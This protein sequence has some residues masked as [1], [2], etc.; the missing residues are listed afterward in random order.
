MTEIERNLRL[1]AS[2]EELRSIGPWLTECLQ[3]TD[4][5]ARVGE[6]ELAVH[7]VAVNIV[8]HAYDDTSRPSGTVEINAVT[9]GNSL[10]VQLVD[11]GRAFE[12]WPAAPDLSEPQVRGYGLMIAQQLASS[13][14]HARVDDKNRW[15]L[16]FEG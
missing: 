10:V 16:S 15:T 1:A 6:I 8:D 4:L 9:T 13:I 3:A 5:A 11:H 7:E 12:A 2:Y 14:D